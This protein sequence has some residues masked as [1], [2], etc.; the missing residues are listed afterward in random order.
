MKILVTGAH[1]FL[2][3]SVLRQAVGE[4][5]LVACG[6]RHEPPPETPAYTRVDLLDG[7]AVTRLLARERPDWVIHTAAL[8]DVDLCETER[9]LARRVNLEMV[10]N[11]ADGCGEVDAGLT[12]LSTDYVFDGRAGPYGE[13]DRTNPLS[14]YGQ[15]KLESEARVLA[16]GIRGLVLRTLWLYGYVPEARR[17]LVTWPL[18]ALAEG[19][20]LAIVHDQWGNPTFVGDVAR[21]LLELCLRGSTGLFHLGG[22]D[23]MTRHEL[24]QELARFFGLDAG[25]VRAVPTEQVGQRALRPLRSGLRWDRVAAELGREP[26]GFAA[27]LEAMKKELDFR[28]DFADLT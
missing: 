8:T 27:G 5:E 1:G 23:Y 11:L 17:N 4:A 25:R 12:H 20:E 28:R 3:R 16:S 9:D 13:E 26:M 18:K 10:G 14:H 2:G 7:A 21:C 19:E 24:V 6:R 22:A 15:V